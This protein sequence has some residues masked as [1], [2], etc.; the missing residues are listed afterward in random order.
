MSEW[1]IGIGSAWSV[2]LFQSQPD[3]RYGVQTISW[4]RELTRDSGPGFLKGRLAWAVEVMP[5]FRQTRPAGVYGFGV[6]PLLWR[7]NFVPRPRWSAFSELSMGG[8]WSSA[9]IPEQTARA[10]FTAHWGVG[11]RLRASPRRQVV[12]A[13]RFQHISNGNQLSANPGV[14]SHLVFVGVSVTGKR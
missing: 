5:V 9:A 4:G 14:N 12:V 1:I 7:W 11:L 10:N 3:R 2:G 8:L 13:Y 6:A